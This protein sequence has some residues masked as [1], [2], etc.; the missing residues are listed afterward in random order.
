MTSKCRDCGL[1]ITFVKMQSGKSV[2]VAPAPDERGTI[3]ARRLRGRWVDGVTVYRLTV[4]I[5]PDQRRLMHH[6][7]VCTH[8]KALPKRRPIP[9][10]ADLT[11]PQQ[12]TLV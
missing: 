9:K 5:A 8:P 1:E 11:T 12:P 2:P 10:L 7:G 6:R 4:K 3:V